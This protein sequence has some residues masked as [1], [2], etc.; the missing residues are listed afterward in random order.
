MTEKLEINNIK[1]QIDLPIGQSTGYLEG[2]SPLEMLTHTW[3]G[4]TCKWASKQQFQINLYY[5]TIIINMSTSRWVR[6]LKAWINGKHPGKWLGNQKCHST[7]GPPM[8]D[9]A[10]RQ[11]ARIDWSGKIRKSTMKCHIEYWAAKNENEKRKTK[12]WNSDSPI[13]LGR[14]H[15]RV[16]ERGKCD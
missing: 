15:Y 12:Q 6:V 11:R 4:F 7:K 16:S 5:F 8:I 10:T 9:R 14:N 2:I 3:W 1:M 13:R